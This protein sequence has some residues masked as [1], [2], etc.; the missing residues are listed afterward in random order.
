MARLPAR[1]LMPAS[2]SSAFC[3]VAATVASAADAAS[4]TDA[5][6]SPVAAALSTSSDSGRLS[7]ARIL[8]AST[9][10]AGGVSRSS[11]LTAA[12]PSLGALH[13]ERTAVT[14]VR[15]PSQ[16]T[17]VDR[18]FGAA[19]S[20]IREASFREASSLFSPSESE[21]A[22]R[23]SPLPLPL[24]LL[25]APPEAA[26]PL[27]PLT[28]LP[29]RA[30]GRSPAAAALI[31]VPFAPFPAAAIT[32]FPKAGTTPGIAAETRPVPGA[33]AAV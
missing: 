19:P 25:S 2:R 28:P 24:S 13:S 30:V 15:R 17:A 1:G 18:A 20:N 23:P 27:A 9:R 3:H 11:R 7:R 16:R 4:R 14:P 10:L 5:S 21:E 29:G 6:A 33:A 22:E 12:A 32:P 8:A 26:I 31:G